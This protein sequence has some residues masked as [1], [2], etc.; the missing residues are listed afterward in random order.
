MNDTKDLN[1]KVAL[2]NDIW[3]VH[4]VKERKLSYFGAINCDHGALN[5]PILD[6]A[7]S[8]TQTQEGPNMRIK[9]S[10]LA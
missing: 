1:L 5:I 3:S 2:W 10:S 8:A 7:A 6:Y 4:I 9:V